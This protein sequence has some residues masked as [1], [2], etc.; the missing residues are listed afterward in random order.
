M[1]QKKLVFDV[2][3][4][5]G[6]DNLFELRFQ[7][8]HDIVDYFFIF[9]TEDNLINIE[10]YYDTQDSKIKTFPVEETFSAGLVDGELISTL[11]L[12][13]LK[14]NYVSFEDSIFFSFSNELP[15]ISLLD[16]FELKSK[17][18]NFLICDVFEG[19]FERKRKYSE[20]GPILVNFSY[21]LKNKKNF[22]HEI[23]NYKLNYKPQ[24]LCIKNGLK[25]FN[26][27]KSTTNLPTYYQCPFSGKFIEYIFERTNRKFVF[28][29]NVDIN[30]VDCDYIFKLKFVKKFPERNFI[31]L[32]NKTQDLEIFIPE[33]PLYY[34][35][36]KDFQSNYKINEIYRIL[37]TFDCKDEDDIEIYFEQDSAKK[38]KFYELKNPSFREGFK[39]F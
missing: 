31:D 16:E 20:L 8:L 38:I 15:D 21:I 3:F 10:K 17:E 13:S 26:Y 22:L 1:V 34:T 23:F 27:T 5:T 7:K 24:E 28:F 12:D 30:D 6:D 2:V 18:V 32:R 14:E 19:N 35:N 25:I 37:S 9:G 11:I 4:L 29:C 36:F 39:L 33:T